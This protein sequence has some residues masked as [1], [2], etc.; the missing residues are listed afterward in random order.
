MVRLLDGRGGRCNQSVGADEELRK[1]SDNG[2]FNFVKQALQS[3][4][5]FALLF[6][7]G[8]SSFYRDTI[9]RKA[10]LMVGVG[11]NFYGFAIHRV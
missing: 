2:N 10:V 8:P 1:F 9:V 6:N 11:P 5:L 4:I 7:E 3:E